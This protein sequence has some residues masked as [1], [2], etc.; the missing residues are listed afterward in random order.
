MGPFDAALLASVVTLTTPILLVALGELVAERSGILNVGLEGMILTGAL[1]AF[2]TTHYTGSTLLGCLGGAAGA[3]AMAA[4]MAVLAIE[5]RADQMV[6]GIGINILAAGVTAFVFESVFSGGEQIVVSRMPD[7]P[8]PLLS[9]LPVVGDAIFSQNLLVY[10]AF[11]GIGAVAYMLSRTNWGLAIRATGELPEAADTAGINVRRVRWLTTLGAGLGSGLGGAY[12]VVG[13][14]G[15][16]TENMSG[17]RGYLALAVVI[18]AKWRARGVIFASL[19]FGG[20][21][22]LQLRLQA[23]DGVPSQVW[24]AIAL[25]AI[26]YALWVALRPSVEA[27]R[28][29]DVSVGPPRVKP[30]AWATAFA[31]TGIVLAIADPSVSLPTQ[32]WLAVPY[33]AA[34]LALAGLV[35]RSRMPSA[36]AVPYSRG[37]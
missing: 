8:I 30:I 10:V 26:A 27:R 22:A 13:G 16:F 31:I 25:V 15:V 36:L 19:L 20:A 14:A 4:V 2:M 5:A 34:L 18:F 29:P 3:I 9:H 32:L 12:L 35:G 7:V 21:E 11:L 37:D 28:R 23:T 17:G 6:V 1:T 33:L 24:V